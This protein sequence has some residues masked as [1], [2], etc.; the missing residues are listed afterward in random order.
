MLS[1]AIKILV[2]YIVLYIIISTVVSA[3]IAKQLPPNGDMTA[4]LVGC[5]FILGPLVAAIM[6]LSAII[7]IIGVII[8]FMSG[9]RSIGGEDE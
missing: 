1:G 4:F 7:V 8:L 5:A 9:Q 6:I 3:E 2:L